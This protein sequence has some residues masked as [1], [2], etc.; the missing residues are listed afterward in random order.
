MSEYVEVV[1]DTSV[2]VISETP[3]VVEISTM[4]VQG[5]PGPT[6]VSTDSG[7]MAILGSDSLIFVSHEISVGT[8]PPTD[9]SMV[10]IDT[11]GV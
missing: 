9:V 11:T 7:N 1:N 6:A 2:V 5:T 10:W 3:N 4:G 8:T